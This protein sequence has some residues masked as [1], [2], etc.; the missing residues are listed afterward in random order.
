MIKNMDY[1]QLVSDIV[2]VRAFKSSMRRLLSDQVGSGETLPDSI[3]IYLSPGSVRAACSVPLRSF[4]SLQNARAALGSEH[5]LH[6]LQQDVASIIATAMDGDRGAMVSTGPIDVS[7]ADAGITDSLTGKDVTATPSGGIGRITWIFVILGVAFAVVAIL[8]RSMDT[9]QILKDLP[10]SISDWCYT[11]DGNASNRSLMVAPISTITGAGNGGG[12]TDWPNQVDNDQGDEDLR[13]ALVAS[14][15]TGDPQGFTEPEPV[16]KP[17]GQATDHMDIEMALN[18]LEDTEQFVYGQA[19][20]DI[21]EGRAFVLRSALALKEFLL[22]RTALR[23]S[24]LDSALKEASG[25]SNQLDRKGFLNILRTHAAD[26]NEVVECYFDLESQDGVLSPETCRH[27]L[28]IFAQSVDLAGYSEEVR[29]RIIESTGIESP[30]EIT[31]EVWIERC[32]RLMR[33]V[34]LMEYCGLAE[35]ARNA[36]C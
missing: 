4:G 16:N 35:T 29:N 6:K 13:R 18:E 24:E 9:R 31:M 36:N 27:G 10:Q 5:S 7:I 3:S 34:R 26:S 32:Q 15:S 25:N 20:G 19:F 23:A 21:A 1:S 30:R 11:R 12:R 14:S 2:F 22:T 28:A 33:I 8:S 17:L